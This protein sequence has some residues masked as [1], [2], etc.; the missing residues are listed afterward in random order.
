[1]KKTPTQ[2]YI[3]GAVE[4]MA[5][6]AKPTTL[7]NDRFPENEFEGEA[8]LDYCL[9]Q[10]LLENFEDRQSYLLKYRDDV[11]NCINKKEK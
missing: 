6:A 7:I 1:M 8:I 2:K 3:D 5:A 4:K 9:E 10:L 11:D